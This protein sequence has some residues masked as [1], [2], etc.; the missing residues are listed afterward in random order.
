MAKASG[1]QRPRRRFG[2]VRKLPSGRYQAGYL[3]P[4][5]S[6]IYAEQTFPTKAMADRFLVLTESALVGGTW[7]SPERQRETVGEWA[8]RW[9]A[10]GH[11]WKPK[12]KAWHTWLLRCH[13]LPRWGDTA[14]GDVRREDV[15]TWATELGAS[16]LSAMTVRHI[17][18]VLGRVFVLAVDS[19]AIPVNPCVALR[20]PSPRRQHEMRFLTVK[21]VEALATAISHPEIRL[22]GHGAGPHW[23][24]DRSDLALAIRLAA[25]CGPRAG[26]LWA[27]RRGRVDLAIG[28]L[29][30]QE[31]LSDAGGRLSFGSTKTDRARAVP[32]PPSLVPDLRHHLASE[33]GPDAEAL[34]F[35]AADGR[36][37]SH[38]N[39]YRRHFKPAVRSAGVPPDLRFH[40]LRHTYIALLIAQGAHPRSVM[41]RA[42]HSSITVTMGTY[43]HLFP[44]LEA[45]LTDKLDQAISS[46]RSHGQLHVDC[47]PVDKDDTDPTDYVP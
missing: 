8:K 24:T 39:F 26:E 23:R 38:A 40:D 3:A 11:A 1:P 14:I 15:R 5:G 21:Q 17:V 13:V 12:T 42:G 4:D 36:P 29:F 30:I 34:V 44:G 33:V 41:E 46:E 27:L 25:Y 20:L 32:I 6:V 35:S 47:T 22:A 10:G 18:G 19:E 2:R 7:T 31:S 16:G 37:V 28:R 9:M 45:D 43:G